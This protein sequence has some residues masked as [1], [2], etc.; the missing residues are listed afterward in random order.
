ML[1]CPRLTGTLASPIQQCWRLYLPPGSHVLPASAPL[2]GLE[3]H[4][5]HPVVATCK[6]SAHKGSFRPLS[7]VWSQNLISFICTRSL[8]PSLS[9]CEVCVDAW[10]EIFQLRV[11]LRE[12]SSRCTATPSSPEITLLQDLLVHTRGCLHDARTVF[13]THAQDNFVK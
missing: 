3:G 12:L 5:F 7:P 6:E 11:A 8:R 13:L 1:G 2:S 9:G 4:L 10:Q